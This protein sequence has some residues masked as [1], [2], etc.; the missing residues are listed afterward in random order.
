MFIT[1]EGP[2]GVGKTTVLQGLKQIYPDALYIREPGTTEAGEHIRNILLTIS[3]KL[4]LPSELLLFT[5]SFSETSAK[6][7]RPALDKAKLVIADR[8]YFSTEAYQCYGNRLP[9]SRSLLSCIREFANIQEPD[10][11]IVLMASWETLCE[12]LAKRDN[13]DKME[14]RGLSF[15]HRVYD[16]YKDIC[17]GVRVSTEATK[18]CTVQEVVNCIES[19]G[20]NK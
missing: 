6:V 3:Q 13:L 7:I 11:N 1:I 2:D 10:L 5:A 18:D 19:Q 12:R 17:P 9:F 14:I 20:V 15:K 4:E 8:W 16:Y